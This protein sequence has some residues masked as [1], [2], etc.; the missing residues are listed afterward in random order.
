MAT[1]PPAPGPS[2]LHPCLPGPPIL[3]L[4]FL[5]SLVT[6]SVLQSPT[7]PLNPFGLP[8]SASL[9]PQPPYSAPSGFSAPRFTPICLKSPPEPHSCEVSPPVP[10]PG[11]PHSRDPPWPHLLLR[12]SLPSEPLLAGPAHFPSPAA[13]GSAQAQSGRG[14]AG[15]GLC[16][17]LAASLPFRYRWRRAALHP[18]RVA[19]RH[20]P[21]PGFWSKM[22]DHWRTASLLKPRVVV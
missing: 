16:C 15:S 8:V 17:P 10:C 18:K 14:R 11:P 12:R 2:G 5:R 20:G 4:G 13:S 7:L 6:P 9:P 21:H 3:C 1:P 22:C 19:R